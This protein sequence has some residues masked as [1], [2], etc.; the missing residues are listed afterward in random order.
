MDK[1]ARRGAIVKAISIITRF[2]FAHAF[3]P[4]LSAALEKYLILPA[5]PAD[6]SEDARAADEAARLAVLEQLYSVLNSIDIAN[7][8]PNYSPLEQRALAWLRV[9]RLTVSVAQGC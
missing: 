7:T 5:L 2:R 4:L 9:L 8:L 1:T 6:A 3:K